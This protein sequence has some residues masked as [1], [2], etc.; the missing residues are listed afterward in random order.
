MLFKIGDKMKKGQGLSL[1]MI[2]I[3][4]LALIILIV[5]VLIF[6]GKVGKTSEGVSE[7]QKSVDIKKC[8]IPGVRKC[9]DSRNCAIKI[10]DSEL[11]NSCESPLVCCKVE[12]LK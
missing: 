4:A 5:L 6:S 12:N 8:D 7:V 1:N 3:A 11:E 9:V 10:I 2:I